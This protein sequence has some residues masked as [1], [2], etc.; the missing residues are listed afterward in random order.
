[1]RS[2][3]QGH[4]QAWSPKRSAVPSHKAHGA[5][6]GDTGS[7]SRS[8]SMMR[9]RLESAFGRRMQPTPRPRLLE[10]GKVRPKGLPTRRGGRQLNDSR[11]VQRR[12]HGLRRRQEAVGWLAGHVERGKSSLSEVAMVAVGRVELPGARSSGQHRSQ[13]GRAAPKAPTRSAQ[14]SLHL[15]GGSEGD[16]TKSFQA[17]EDLMVEGTHGA[18]KQEQSCL[19]IRQVLKSPQQRK[20]LLQGVGLTEDVRPNRGNQQ[21]GS[22]SHVEGD[23]SREGVHVNRVGDAGAGDELALSGV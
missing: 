19:G 4:A 16:P 3:P 20:P 5:S 14:S 8:C 11:L 21:R 13:V 10:Q 6:A 1:M 7:R 15:G 9:K 2:P 23:A 12:R 17:A 22:A 18:S